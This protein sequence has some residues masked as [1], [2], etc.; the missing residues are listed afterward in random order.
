MGSVD[1]VHVGKASRNNP[2]AEFEPSL[3]LWIRLYSNNGDVI[4]QVETDIVLLV[5]VNRVNFE[6]LLLEIRYLG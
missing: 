1:N 6:F 4:V 5:E 3:S 2:G